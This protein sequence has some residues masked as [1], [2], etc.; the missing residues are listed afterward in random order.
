M[1]EE[2]GEKQRTQNCKCHSWTFSCK[3]LYSNNKRLAKETEGEKWRTQKT[4]KSVTYV[5]LSLNLCTATTKKRAII[6][7]KTLTHNCSPPATPFCLETICIFSPTSKACLVVV[8]NWFSLCVFVCEPFTGNI[9]DTELMSRTLTTKFHWQISLKAIP[10]LIC[11]NI[12]PVQNLR[13]QNTVSY[14]YYY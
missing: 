1:D 6:K 12:L 14:Y 11:G 2:T 9:T 3:P 8:F 4:I 7:R 10:A 5:H 13:I